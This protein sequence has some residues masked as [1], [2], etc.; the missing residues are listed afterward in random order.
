VT[1][2]NTGTVTTAAVAAAGL[3]SGTRIAVVVVV[4]ASFAVALVMAG[5]IAVDRLAAG[6]RI[7]TGTFCTGIRAAVATAGSIAVCKAAARTSSSSSSCYHMMQVMRLMKRHLRQRRPPALLLDGAMLMVAS[8]VLARSAVAVGMT[9]VLPVDPVA[10]AA[11]WVV[12][13]GL[14]SAMI[15]GTSSLFGRG[16]TVSPTCIAILLPRPRLRSR[17]NSTTTPPTTML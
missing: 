12:A 15:A 4:V 5:T 11:T 6:T 1:R 16:A 17:R 7:A 3:L 14:V 8:A 2:Y 10:A 9:T 13:T